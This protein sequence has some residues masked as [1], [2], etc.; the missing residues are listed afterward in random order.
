MF[1]KQQK[2][3]DSE[4]TIHELSKA[5][6]QFSVA[7]APGIDGFPEE[8]YKHVWNVIKEDVLEVFKESFEEKELPTS[9]KRALLSLLPKKGDLDLENC[10]PVALLCTDYTILAKCFSNRLKKYIGSLIE[11]NLT[12]CCDGIF[13]YGY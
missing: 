5:V 10:R 11:M 8:F 4:I 2:E 13:P 7:K 6:Q 9:S 12:C 3:L 1:N